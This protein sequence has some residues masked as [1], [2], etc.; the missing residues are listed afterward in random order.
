MAD[1]K[2]LHLGCG[3]DILEGWIN[4]DAGLLPGVDVVANLDDCSQTPLPF[5]SD[6]IDEFLMSHVLEH[7]K[8]PFPLME[9]L[10]RITKPDAKITIRLPY[11][12]SD[13]AWMDPTYVRPYFIKSC[14]YFS[15]PMYAFADY[16]YHGDWRTDKVTVFGSKAE[17][18]GLE[19]AA[20]LHK[21]NT[22]RNMVNEMIVEMTAIK[23]I[24]EAKIEFQV[25][26]EIHIE[27]I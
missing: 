13:S 24:R 26:P 8:N 17:H 12:S 10:H 4:L 15:Q 2:R 25:E 16:S 7:L 21:I 9:E 18:E 19:A 6:T 14:L 3:R 22:F 5:E 23:P 1:V 27:L 11:G 20:V